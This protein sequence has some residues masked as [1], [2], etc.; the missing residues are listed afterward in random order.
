V[1]PGTTVFFGQG[2]SLS[3]TANGR[4]CAVGL[5]EKHRGFR[6][7]PLERALTFLRDPARTPPHLVDRFEISE[8]F[9]YA[10]LCWKHS[11]FSITQYMAL[12]SVQ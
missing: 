1:S 10:S 2:S 7:C 5:R 9:A 6:S 12:F 8:G 4:L 11:G 3:V